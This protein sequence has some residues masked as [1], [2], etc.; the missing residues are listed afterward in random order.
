M[1][2]DGSKQSDGR[3]GSGWLISDTFPLD[4]PWTDMARL[5]DH[6]T[7]FQAEMYAIQ[8]ATTDLLAPT[9][10]Y[11]NFTVHYFTE[12]MSSLQAFD[13]I[14]PTSLLVKD[15]I[16]TLNL[17]EPNHSITLHWVRGHSGIAGNESA[18]RLANEVTALDNIS[19]C[20]F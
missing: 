20:N 15:T 7:V 11:K 9:C 19:I 18:D 12:S 13:N 2:T 3:T 4:E 5:P 10:A 16:S 14:Y 1:Y 17:L 6:A 8:A